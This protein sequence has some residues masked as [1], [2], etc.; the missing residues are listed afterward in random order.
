MQLVV[1]QRAWL[2]LWEHVLGQHAECDWPKCC[3]EAV[4]FVGWWCVVRRVWWCVG[5]CVVCGWW[6]CGEAVG[7][8]TVQEISE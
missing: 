6:C 7:H 4:G 8:K 1:A 2:P 5:W 3:G